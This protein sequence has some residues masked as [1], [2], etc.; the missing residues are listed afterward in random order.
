VSDLEAAFAAI[1]ASN[2]VDPVRVVWNGADHARARLH[3]ERASY[4]LRR[5]GAVDGAIASEAVQ[6]A[7]RA[8][9]LRRWA[10]PRSSYPEGRSGYHRWKKAQRDAL[11]ASFH[12]VLAPLGVDDAVIGRAAQLASRVGLGTDPETQ[13]VE[14]A[15]CL[16]FC[17]IDL[18]DVLAQI[19]PDKT[20]EA[21]RKTLPKMS[22]AAIGLA[23]EATPPGP[24]FD[25]LVAIATA[26]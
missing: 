24:A 16:V 6:L 18:A 4:W 22:P 25:L 9:H 17:E 15:A 23:P 8:H 26:A 3:G 21:I 12:E 13:L 14:D 2:D 7:V 10:I 11:A 1:D 19:G 5:L 20:A